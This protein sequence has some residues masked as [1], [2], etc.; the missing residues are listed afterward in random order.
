MVSFLV[1]ERRRELSI[2]MALGAASGDILRLVVGQGAK[3]AVAGIGVGV[4]LS[5]AAARVLT[6]LLYGTTATDPVA[7]IG[8]ALLLGAVALAASWVPARRAARMPPSEVL[9]G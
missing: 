3:M 1:A 5:L 8:V 6:G 9:R 7:F 4:L 2:R